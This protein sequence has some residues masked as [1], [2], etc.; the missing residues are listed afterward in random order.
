MRS[1]ASFM[2]TKTELEINL[3]SALSHIHKS[4][5]LPFSPCLSFMFPFAY[6]VHLDSSFSP[7][8]C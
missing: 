1:R 3:F 7:S 2:N 4:L 8:L 5:S 6:A